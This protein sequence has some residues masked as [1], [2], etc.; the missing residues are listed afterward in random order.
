MTVML[1]IIKNGKEIETKYLGNGWYCD[2]EEHYHVEEDIISSTGM[3][4][5]N[6]KKL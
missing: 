5:C 4:D 6:C 2:G 1:I 3:K